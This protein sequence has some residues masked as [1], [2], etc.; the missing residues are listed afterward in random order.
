MLVLVLVLGLVGVVFATPAAHAR[1]GWRSL[2]WVASDNLERITVHGGQIWSASKRWNGTSWISNGSLTAANA[3]Y[4]DI[5]TDGTT[6]H[7][8][9]RSQTI[10][11]A[12]RVDK[13]N[14]S[15]W[16][17]V[18]GN[19][20]VTSTQGDPLDLAMD[21][22]SPV[23]LAEDTSDDVYA[24]R[25]N[26]SSWS[27]LGGPVNDTPHA[28]GL[29]LEVIAG[30]TYAAVSQYQDFRRVIVVKRWTGSAW[31]PLEDA[32]VPGSERSGI[33]PDLMSV[34]GQLWM[35]FSDHTATLLSVHRWTGSSW[36]V[37]APNLDPISNWSGSAPRELPVFNPT[38][39]GGA[40]AAWPTGN[41]TA[42]ATWDGTTWRELGDPYGMDRRLI[43]V[44]YFG[45]Q[46]VITGRLTQVWDPNVMTMD[47]S[48]VSDRSAEVLWTW[49]RSGCTT[50][51]M[52][53]TFTQLRLRPISWGALNSIC[54]WGYDEEFLETPANFAG[55]AAGE[56]ELQDL[57]SNAQVVTAIEFAT[58]WGAS[59]TS[60]A[61][62]LTQNLRLNSGANLLAP[63]TST[64]LPYGGQ[65]NFAH[66][67]A[68]GLSIAPSD[69]NGA[70]ARITASWAS[71]DPGNSQLVLA[72]VGGRVHYVP[73]PGSPPNAPV[74][75]VQQSSTL[76]SV[77]PTGSVTRDGIDSA[78]RLSMTSSDPDNV[79]SLPL[80]I[81]A[82]VQPDSSSFTGT[83][84]VSGPNMF[85][86]DTEYMYIAVTGLVAG[87]TYK[88]RACTVDD[89]GNVGPWSTFNAGG[90]AFTV[91]Q[92]PEVPDLVSP[93]DG[94]A[95]GL[96]PLVARYR[97]PGGVTGSI[98]FQTCASVSCYTVTATGSS[99]GGLTSGSLG[100]WSPASMVAWRARSVDA[101]GFASAWSEVSSYSVVAPG[102]V[103]TEG[104][105]WGESTGTTATASVTR[106]MAAGTRL[107]ISASMLGSATVT[108]IV[109]LHGTVYTLDRRQANGTTLGTEVWSGVLT[110]HWF[111]G[112]TF[113]VTFS[114]SPGAWAVDL[115]LYS[116]LGAR[117]VSSGNSS[118]TST[119]PTTSIT[120]TVSNS[121]IH[122]AVG[123]NG[124][125]SYWSAAGAGYT[126]VTSYGDSNGGANGNLGMAIEYRTASP[127]T[128][129]V[130]A[131]LTNSRPWAVS[132]VAYVLGTG[133]SQPSPMAT[134]AITGN[135]Y[136]GQ[137]LTAVP[138]SWSNSPTFSYQW[139]R[140][141]GEACSDI[142]GATSTTY[143]VA[144]GDVGARIE[145]LVTATN[146]GGAASIF[147]PQVGPIELEPNWA[148]LAPTHVTPATGS[149]TSDTT[150]EL[151]ATFLDPNGSETGTLQFELC[152]V[153]MAASQTCAAAGGTVVASMSASSVAKDANGSASPVA[154]LAYGTY[155]WHVRGSD[156]ALTGPW[157]ASW[158]L[159]VQRAPTAPI[160][161]SPVSASVTT[162]TTPELIATFQ[163]PDVGQTGSVEFE[164]CTVAMAAG[165][166]CAGAGGSVLATFASASGVAIGANA[167][168]S[169]ASAI[170]GG[171]LHWHARGSDQYGVSGPWSASWSLIIA[172]A[173]S[174]P[175][176]TSPASGSATADTTPQL[177]A[178]F[179]DPDVGNTGTVHFELCTVAMAAGQS[180]IG[181]GGSVVSTW[182]S[183]SGIAIGTSAA[184]NPG[185]AI[186][187]GSY[188]WHA[189]GE[190]QTSLLGPWSSSWALRIGLP[191][192]SVS[193]D[194]TSVALGMLMPGVDGVATSTI[195]ITTDSASGYTL[196]ATD[197]DNAWGL[198]DGVN[199]IVDHPGSCDGPVVWAAA[200]ALGFGITVRDATGGRLAKWGAGTGTAETNFV[201]NRYCGLDSGTGSVLHSRTTYSSGPDTVQMTMR[202]DVST[203]QAPG[204]YQGA[205]VL[206][207]TANP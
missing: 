129:S 17:T 151:V 56:W 205:L 4:I 12:L 73:A 190:D 65:T 27:V 49:R 48:P 116:G 37:A 43:D 97:H 169:P 193:V 203:A 2:D 67:I 144:A 195:T 93:L 53:D 92:P 113:T 26:G 140:C 96:V 7:V 102:S 194:A 1:G 109:D 149:G 95:G 89:Y 128:Y 154:A 85:T 40:I 171:T 152:T 168:A 91:G 72:D 14:G 107:V 28:T 134:G 204:S 78:I 60:V 121:L 39:S 29:S 62:S 157:S 126:F 21:G 199:S 174:A 80:S 155:H 162:D 61:P 24:Y 143:V 15:S 100:S 200:A 186:A 139:R 182:S 52:T 161:V 13:W 31:A 130:N 187:N 103:V 66:Q 175:V 173:P 185:T 45:G 5:E 46:P 150:P 188:H 183:A 19:L 18:G 201:D 176:H 82:E 148:P 117:D 178:T 20:P 124:H 115:R 99:A 108:S 3:E 132:G 138:G 189:R 136:L 156:E 10:P 32:G 76:S 57:P 135:T 167:T 34:G 207:G 170:A 160:H 146:A 164:A 75:L 22:S 112:D 179:E 47:F 94:S 25:W 111:A 79:N 30:T 159:V 184:A 125:A 105:A 36:V 127:A 106:S 70:Y 23:V 101:N 165:Q 87:E 58:R 191:S 55:M 114:A 153:A 142:T 51:T 44:E 6:P 38:P 119:T 192:M 110:E 77:I 122:G 141:V 68:T 90:A 35:G 54:G 16:V 181:A 172:N 198:D 33:G 59:T 177:A 166:S 197:E 9:Y 104:G 74:S 88:W 71:S 83:C 202:A 50:T 86:T 64:G 84:G 41:G 196:T 131:T 158:S 69:F 11:T 133:T 123:W 120:P 137:T 8:A 118:G 81:W 147:L 163:D 63:S 206:S 145:V 42:A 98:E 180:C